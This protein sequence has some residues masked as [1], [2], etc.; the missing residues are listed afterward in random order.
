MWN[1]LDNRIVNG[2]AWDSWEVF[3]EISFGIDWTSRAIMKSR[4][5]REVF[6]FLGSKLR[7]CPIP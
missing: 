7:D 1:F 3:Y 2:L 6:R 5:N 4:T